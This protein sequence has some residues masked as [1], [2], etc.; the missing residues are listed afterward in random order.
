[1]L[2]EYE[3]MFDIRRLDDTTKIFTSIDQDENK[4]ELSEF[5][6]TIYEETNGTHLN[7]VSFLGQNDEYYL[8][9][10]VLLKCY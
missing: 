3:Y 4:H 7:V 10:G 6:C 1:M 9:D 5:F 2:A 8:K